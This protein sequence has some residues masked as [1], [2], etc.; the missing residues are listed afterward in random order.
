MARDRRD[1][2]LEFAHAALSLRWLALASLI[3]LGT[4]TP[5]SVRTPPLFYL[6]ILIYTLGLSLYAWRYADRALQAAQIG[7]VLDTVAIGVGMQ[8][9]SDPHTFFYFGFV[10]AAVAGLLMAR[11]GTAVIAGV[12]GL[13]QFP[14]VSGSVFTPNLYIAWGVAALAL[15]A[16][17]QVAAVATT[18]LRRRVNL[19]GLLASLGRIS[20]LASTTAEA[21][22]RVLAEI[23]GFLGAGS[24]SLMLFDPQDGRLEILAAYRLGD[25][26][27]QVRPRLDEGIA[28]WVTQA[29]QPVLLTPGA[30]APFPLLRKEIGSSMCVPVSSGGRPLGV[31]NV[32]RATDRAWFSPDDLVTAG[33]AARH[34]ADI[35]F[36]AQHERAIAATLM[37]VTSGFIGV[38]RAILRDPAVLWPVLL[39]Q[40]RSLTGAQFAVLALERQDTG[41]L[42]VVASR[43]I[44]GQAALSFLPGL[45]AASTDGRLHVAGEHPHAGLAGS[46]R[47][48]ADNSGPIVACVPL[49]LEN[50]KVGA[51]GLGLPGG[52]PVLPHQLEAVAALVAGAVH[53]ARTANRLADI[54]VVEERRRIAREMHDGLAQTLADAML[55]TDLSAMTAQG[56]PA[57][58]TGDLKELR[59]L[60]ERGMRELREFMSELR[61][62]P[63]TRGKLSAALEEL[64]R[65]F[66]RRD[67]IPTS[68]VVTGDAARLPS[69]AKYAILAIVRQ[70]LTNVRTHARATA[71]T[72]RAEIAPDACTTSVTD[73][74]V[75]FDLAAFRAQPP[76]PQ[77]L[78]LVS[79]EERAGLVGGQL[80]IDTAPGRGTTV[81]IRIPVSP[82]GHPTLSH[83]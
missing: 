19:Q 45:L 37:N 27:R 26:Y 15:Q 77:H 14:L 63:E 40:T 71:V 64:G 39:D 31:L 34:I 12:V 8:V 83:G 51:I 61:R 50:R 5:A 55:Q 10:T 72:I 44:A 20:G 66:Q 13:L 25:I 57:Q 17:G 68:V 60:L 58:V 62:E 29:G 49:R 48:G 33:L 6:G 79:M 1:E 9:A 59:A 78:G 65:E 67:E 41:T 28:G 82:I 24:G 56:N 30:S 22:D 42:D 47:S 52:T 35:L 74:G 3:A 43:G 80:E 70:A 36:R 73:N 32:N 18:H 81:R 4:L 38:S 69:A 76:G 23:T 2:L 7:V 53:T 21:A 11:V 54:G 75:G 46:G 16:A